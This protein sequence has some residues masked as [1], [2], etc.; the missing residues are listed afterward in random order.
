MAQGDVIVFDQACVDILEALHDLETGS[1]KL[2]LI[3]SAVTPAVTDADPRFG[4]GGSTNYA[5]NECAAGGNYASGGPALANPT[6]T[7]TGGLAMFD[8]DDLTIAQ[9]AGNPTNARWGIIY[10]TA[11]GLRAI[12]AVDLGSTFD[13]TTGPLAFVWS[14]NGICR[15]NN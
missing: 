7:L 6:V 10:N 11:A 15:L 5:T 3:T 9:N 14:A 2:G 4:A 8:A 12:A 1:F 13:M